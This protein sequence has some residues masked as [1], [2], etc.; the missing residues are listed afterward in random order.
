MDTPRNPFKL[1]RIDALD[2]PLSPKRRLVGRGVCTALGGT[3]SAPPSQGLF[4]PVLQIS[5]DALHR[6][7]IAGDIPFA[8]KC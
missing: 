6:V 2:I 7:V 4:G 8:H 3:K 1:L 5:G